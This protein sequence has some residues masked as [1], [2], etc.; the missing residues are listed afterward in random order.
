[1]KKT[2]KIMSLVMALL[3]LGLNFLMLYTEDTYEIA[4]LE[5]T[6][7][8]AETSGFCSIAANLITPSIIF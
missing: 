4:E 2:V 5:E 8:A 1:M 6:V 7:I 3:L